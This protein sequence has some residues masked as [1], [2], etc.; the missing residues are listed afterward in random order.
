MNRPNSDNLEFGQNKKN[1]PFIFRR[2]V[3]YQASFVRTVRGVTM[4]VAPG[5]QCTTRPHALLYNLW[6]Y[7]YYSR[8]FG[9]CNDVNL[10]APVSICHVETPLKAWDPTKLLWPARRH[11]VLGR[12]ST[13]ACYSAHG[14]CSSDGSRIMSA[15]MRRT[16]D[17][18]PRLSIMVRI[19]Q[20][21]NKRRYNSFV[22]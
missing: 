20:A 6:E 15:R 10:K 4:L 9:I 22:K 16:P 21:L 11:R 12:K 13:E 19:K 7:C 2:G 1:L 18:G 8:Y 5:L 17:G 3:S 14:T